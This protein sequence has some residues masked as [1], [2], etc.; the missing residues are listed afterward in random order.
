[1]SDTNDTTETN[2]TI[3][4]SSTAD[5]LPGPTIRWGALAWGLIFASIAGVVLWLSTGADRRD[6]VEAWLRT[7]GPVEFGLYA[8]LALGALAVVFGVVGLIR[9]GERQRAVRR[10]HEAS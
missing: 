4:T 8:I 2:D 1:M 5:A 9:R 6:A 10:R 7:I 3:E